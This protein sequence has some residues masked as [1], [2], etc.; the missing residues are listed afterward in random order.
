MYNIVNSQNICLALFVQ[1][2]PRIYLLSVIRYL[3]EYSMLT[4]IKHDVE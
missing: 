2:R 1:L 3:C 4:Y